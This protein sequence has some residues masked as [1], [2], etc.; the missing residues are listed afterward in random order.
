M[1]PA[2]TLVAVAHGSRDPRSAAT[3]SALVDRVRWL[4]PDL[5]V[6]LAFL[7][8][9][10]PRL[11][12][13]LDSVPRAVVVPLLLGRAFHAEVDVPGAVA[14][15]VARRP[16]LDITVADVLGP[17]PRLETAALR[18]LAEVGVS[19]TDPD[20]GVVLAA[21][22]SQQAPANAAVA[23]IAATWSRRTR[24]R[25]L[26]GFACAARPTVPEAIATLQ[27]HG[28]RRIAVAP[29]FLAPGLLP[30]KVF[31][32][33]RTTDP[34]SLNAA[35]LG[36]DPAIAKLIVHRFEATLLSS[37]ARSA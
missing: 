34:Q 7:D 20:F 4:R 3:I 12:A 21:A 19:P 18:Q 26:P 11:D 17:D 24:W 13:V 30:N 32:Q 2:P 16:R 27:S 37:L 10:A 5:D 35:P 14:R 15:A 1:K 9:C 23:A 8:L 25:V 29:W 6:R 28:A 22:G 36:A 31:R 33:A